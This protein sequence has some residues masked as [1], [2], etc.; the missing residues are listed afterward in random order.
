MKKKNE[1][2]GLEAIRKELKELIAKK[3]SMRGLKPEKIKDDEILFGRGLELD[4]LDAVELVVLL[5]RRYGIRM[6]ELEWDRKVFYSVDTLAR[7][8]HKVLKKR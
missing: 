2:H 8:V 5:Q 4:S 6:K 1:Q 7:Y 3:F